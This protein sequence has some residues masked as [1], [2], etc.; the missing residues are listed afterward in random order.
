LVSKR[1]GVSSG[2]FS[3]FTLY[4]QNSTFCK[5]AM[6]GS[7]QRPPPCKGKSIM[8]Q[9]FVVV[10]IFLQTDV[11]PLLNRCCCSALFMWIGVLTVYKILVVT[12]MLSHFCMNYS[13]FRGARQIVPPLGGH[14]SYGT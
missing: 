2:P 1:A 9:T 4:L 11:F 7:N 5:W 3:Y 6:L 12:S 10:Q 14:S 13:P 8:P